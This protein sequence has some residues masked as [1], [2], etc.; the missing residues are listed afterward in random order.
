MCTRAKTRQKGLVHAC[1][2]FES[3]FLAVRSR[4]SLIRANPEDVEILQHSHQLLS[5]DELLQCCGFATSCNSS[6]AV[7]LASRSDDPSGGDRGVETKEGG[8]ESR[9][10]AH[11]E[12]YCF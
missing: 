12:A 7:A 11:G 5:V 10:R 8:G 2:S 1:A 3:F 6:S 4:R 9:N